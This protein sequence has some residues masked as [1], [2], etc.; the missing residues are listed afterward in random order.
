MSSHAY[1]QEVLV[2]KFD[3]KPEAAVP[4][5]TLA[6]LGLDSLSI[7]ELMFDVADKYDIDIPDERT[8]INTLGEAVK[9]VDELVRAK[10]G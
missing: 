9:L 1:I 4:E 8:N 7:A 2:K 5:A 6:D 10:H 3:V